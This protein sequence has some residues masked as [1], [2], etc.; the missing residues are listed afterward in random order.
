MT[1][2]SYR[3]YFDM[4][5]TVIIMRLALALISRSSVAFKLYAPSIKCK[6]LPEAENNVDYT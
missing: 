2:Y 6:I 1:Q 5:L 3:C 4:H